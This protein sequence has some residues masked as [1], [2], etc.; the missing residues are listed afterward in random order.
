[1]TI[2]S[3]IFLSRLILLFIVLLFGIAFSAKGDHYYGGYITYKHLGG[4]KYEVTVVTY[5]DNDK[6]NSDRDSIDVI[7][8]DGAKEYIQRINNVGNGETVFPGIKK[9]I[10]QGIHTYSDFGNYQL[11]FIDDFR[12][13]DIDNIAEGKSG[14]T[15]LY[16][17]A[18]A[19]IDKNANVIIVIDALLNIFVYLVPIILTN[20]GI[21]I[22]IKQST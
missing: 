5:A 12:P 9:N 3:N 13:L 19:P 8:G 1:M 10:Y 11:V 2:T 20:V 14:S 16:F 4:Y 15:L 7:W 17:N 18:I 6:V 22:N 21:N